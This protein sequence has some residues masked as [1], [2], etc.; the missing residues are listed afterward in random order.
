MVNSA[1]ITPPAPREKPPSGRGSCGARLATT[2][3]E[4]C[5]RV[6][7]TYARIDVPG[8]RRST[9]AMKGLSLMVRALAWAPPPVR[10]MAAGALEW[11][12]GTGRVPV[13][14]SVEPTAKVMG[15][16]MGSLKAT[17]WAMPWQ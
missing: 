17:G 4:L 7:M 11:E 10:V 5:G 8:R 16:T 2:I 3:A 1:V 6:R 15:M 12:P 13:K 14:G 9:L